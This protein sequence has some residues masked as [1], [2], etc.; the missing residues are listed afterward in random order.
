MSDFAPPIT[1]DDDPDALLALAGALM[2]YR[3]LIILLG[4]AGGLVGGVMGLLTRRTYVSAA[5]FLPQNSDPNLSG[6]ALAATQFGVRLPN[7]ASGGWGPPVY[8]E[9]LRSRV[10]LEPIV[11]DTLEVGEEGRRE[12][13]LDLAKI[14]DGPPAERVDLGI[15]ALGNMVSAQEAKSLTGVRLQVR[16]HWPSVS[17]AIAQRLLDGVQRFNVESRQSQAGAE[18]RFV[19]GQ[20]KDAQQALRDAEDRLQGYLE[21]NRTIASP[22]ATMQRDRLQRDIAQ[23]QQLYTALL[24]SRDDARV[25]EVRDTP[26]ITIVEAPQLPVLP[27]SRRVLLKAIAGGM[28]GGLLGLA[29]AFT[30]RGLMRARRSPSSEAREFADLIDGW[31]SRV[32]KRG[33]S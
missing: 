4:L 25:R 30:A 8:A 20:A 5:A 12:A 31:M 14:P 26:V 21:R 2:R 6:L 13:F 3:K 11:R 7:L 16:S 17:L 23:K 1:A 15:K 33:T 19:E 29:L 22:E 18:R 32:A 24:Q 9:L 28:A 10:L 27:E